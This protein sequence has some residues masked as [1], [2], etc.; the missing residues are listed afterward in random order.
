MGEAGLMTTHQ[1]F[2][3]Y[4]VGWYRLGPRSNGI[5]IGSF[6]IKGTNMPG[7]H[8]LSDAELVTA[9]TG[10]LARQTCRTMKHYAEVETR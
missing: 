4:V 3:L 1:R 8:S 2:N 9:P 6:R 5:R 7:N 10:L